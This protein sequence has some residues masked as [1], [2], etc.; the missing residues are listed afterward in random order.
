MATDPQY[1][2]LVYENIPHG[3]FTVDRRARITSFNSAAERIT[4]YRREEVIGRPCSSIFRTT[5][6]A[7]GCFLRHSVESGLAH[8]D[9]EV[10]IHGRDGSAL[11]VAVST[12]ALLDRRGRAIGGVEMF[13]ELAETALPQ[14]EIRTRPSREPIVTRSPAMKGVCEMLPLV[15]RSDATVL[16]EGEPGSGKDIVA[17][18]IHGMGPRA[19]GPFVAVNCGA[20]PES[21]VESEF[22][23]HVRGAFTDARSN[24]PGRF[25]QAE[26]GTLLLDEVGELSPAVQVK[27]LRVLQE[28]EYTPVGTTRTIKADVRVL[29]ATN[30]NL[31]EEVAAG[32]FRQDLYFRL[33]VVRI[34][35]PP[36]RARPEDIPLLVEHF[37][38]HFDA[39]QG[40]RI[41]SISQPAM[42]TLLRFP[43]PGNVRELENAIEHAFVVS[44]GDTIEIDDLPEHI[45][46]GVSPTKDQVSPTGATPL[47][48]AE[49][50]VIRDALRRSFGRKDLAARELG[51]SRSTLWRKM[52]HHGLTIDRA[53]SKLVN[54]Q[55]PKE[56]P[57]ACPSG[58]EGIATEHVV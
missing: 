16:I 35:L 3:M 54:E 36:L 49:L 52:K 4:G 11:S 6:C 13:R 46:R 42:D 39:A 15:A 17:R 55:P 20:I 32:R 5:L 38:A 51:I 14:G 26:G 45:L 22:F 28:R 27:L 41:R 23:G 21:L 40:R 24:R 9:R 58:P 53:A 33:N 44:G 19:A 37:I 2:D 12:A 57:A 48:R 18:A 7:E 30:R 47:A 50:D 34:V 25:R 56:T 8:R 31:S 43:F 10:T 1:V 29:A